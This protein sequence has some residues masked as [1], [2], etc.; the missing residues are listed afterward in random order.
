MRLTHPDLP[1]QPIDVPESTA[2]ALI[3]HSG[4]ILDSGEPA[5]PTAGKPAAP[6]KEK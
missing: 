1:G 2:Q 6:E 5:G 3:E 4:W